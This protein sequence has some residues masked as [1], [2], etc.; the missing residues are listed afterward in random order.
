MDS[1]IEYAPTNKYLLAMD[2]RAKE[3]ADSLFVQ[4][5]VARGDLQDPYEYY[6]QYTILKTEIP[7]IPKGLQYKKDDVEW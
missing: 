2:S 5:T 7:F 3:K 6:E 4:I 1:P